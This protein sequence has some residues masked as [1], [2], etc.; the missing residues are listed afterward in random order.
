MATFQEVI[1]SSMANRFCTDVVLRDVA[2]AFDKVWHTGLKYKITTLQLHPCYTKILTDYITDRTAAIKIDTYTGPSF[3]L[4]S[5]VP[6]GAC[7]SPTLF[8]FYTH[9]M[10]PPTPHS[11]Y[12]QF[13][14][15]ITQITTNTR[16]YQYAARN[17]QHAID[18]IN[19]YENQWKIQTN[20][21]KFNI[22]PLVRK[23]TAD[24]ETYAEI[25]E[26]TTH[27][28]ILGLNFTKNGIQKHVRIRTNI[29]RDNL[30]KLQRFYNLSTDNKLKLYKSLVRSALTYPIIPMHTVKPSNMIQLQRIQNRALKHITNTKWYHFRT[31]HSLHFQCNIEP[32]NIY[33]HRLAKSHWE[34]IETKEPQLYNTLETLLTP[35]M[36]THIH[37]PSSRRI[38]EGPP[39]DP[40]YR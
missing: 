2:K 1:A 8:S 30:Q 11:E 38:A 21:S 28:K 32:I 7:L 27:G 18:K 36:T 25:L 6:Q 12:I 34:N 26:Y 40:I 3:P 4:L 9:D 23:Q 22:V 17:T 31:A 15:D 10:P 37:F 29:A 33:L 5:G 35:D 39:P 14:D 13:A 20:T 19:T 16:N 24:I